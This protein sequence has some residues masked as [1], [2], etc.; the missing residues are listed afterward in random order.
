[1]NSMLLDRRGRENRFRMSVFVIMH[2]TL[3]RTSMG[4]DK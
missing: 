1:M 3:E 4:H 2:G